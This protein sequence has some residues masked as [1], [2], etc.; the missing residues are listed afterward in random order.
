MVGKARWAEKQIFRVLNVLEALATVDP[1]GSDAPAPVR[2]QFRGYTTTG[3]PQ[4]RGERVRGKWVPIWDH[5]P[6]AMVE[7]AD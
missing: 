5:R 2:W 3:C 7:A 4:G 6:E 1:V